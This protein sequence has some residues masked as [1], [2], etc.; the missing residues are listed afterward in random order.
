MKNEQDIFSSAALSPRDQVSDWANI[1]KAVGDKV[2]GTFQGYWE[3]PAKDGFKAQL[4]IAYRDAEG[5]VW[6]INVNDNS[7]FRS[8]IELSKAGDSIGLRYEGDK[9]TGQIQKAKIIKFY[10]PDLQARKSSG[11]ALGVTK[12]ENQTTNPAASE[13]NSFDDYGDGQ[14]E[15]LPAGD[16]GF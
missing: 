11:V 12:P 2:S 16:P 5:K 9:D 10:N 1:K 13:G 6:G 8:Q 14:A 15:T 7:Y 3:T 4:G